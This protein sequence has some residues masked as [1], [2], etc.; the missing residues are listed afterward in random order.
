MRRTQRQKTAADFWDRG[1][2]RLA[3]AILIQAA[4]DILELPRAA[5]RERLREH[6]FAQSFLYAL[7]AAWFLRRSAFPD[8]FPELAPKLREL[9]E[10]FF[11]AFPPGTA[12]G[13]WI[14]SPDA[15]F[16][17]HIALFRDSFSVEARPQVPAPVLRDVRRRAGILASLI[18]QKTDPEAVLELLQFG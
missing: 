11:R 13:E 12:S 7:S 15:Q 14:R 1:Y 8:F 4:R 5:V 17:V 10:T 9:G 18:R 6:L 2:E 3:L 16:A